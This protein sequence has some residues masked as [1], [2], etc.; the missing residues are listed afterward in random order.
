MMGSKTR[1]RK[2]GGGRSLLG[3]ALRPAR[4]LQGNSAGTM[5]SIRTTALPCRAGEMQGSAGEP[6]GRRS[7]RVA[8]LSQSGRARWCRVARLRR[9]PARVAPGR[10]SPGAGETASPFGGRGRP[11]MFHHAKHLSGKCFPA[12]AHCAVPGV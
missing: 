2:K 9:Y 3:G 7:C 6:K 11:L 5:R 4:R 1:G 10:R 12:T 8:R